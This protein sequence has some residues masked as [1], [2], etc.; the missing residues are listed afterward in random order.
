MVAW[1][2]IL[3]IEAFCREIM[4]VLYYDGFI[5][6]RDFFSVPDCFPVISFLKTV[7]I[8]RAKVILNQSKAWRF[9]KKPG[10][11]FSRDG[12]GILYWRAA[13]RARKDKADSA[14][15]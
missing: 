3:R 11:S 7:Q 8:R 15:G 10:L 5:T 4:I 6:F 13:R 2:K 9:R 14:T 12:S 1:F